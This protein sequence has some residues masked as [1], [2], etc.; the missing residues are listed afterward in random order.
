MPQL[1]DVPRNAAYGKRRDAW[2][3]ATVAV[4]GHGPA[5]LATSEWR[6]RVGKGTKTHVC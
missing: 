3:Y 4:L 1:K 2:A 6:L 5:V